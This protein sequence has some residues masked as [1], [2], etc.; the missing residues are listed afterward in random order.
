MV[1]LGGFGGYVVFGFDHPVV[2]VDGQCDFKVYGNAAADAQYPGYYTSETGIVMV[3]VDAN[4][5]GL[6]DDPW[7][8]LAGSA[9][10]ES[11]KDFSITYTKP[12]TSDTTYPYTTN[13]P[14]RPTGEVERN[15]FHKQSY[16]PEWTGT[17]TLLFSGTA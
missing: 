4:G 7:Y 14:A 1:S 2:N 3:S 5:N 16:W 13:D 11:Y 8:E 10:A 12:A 17:E 15:I 9:Y 6:P